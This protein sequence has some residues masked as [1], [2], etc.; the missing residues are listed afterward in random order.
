MSWLLAPVGYAA[1]VGVLTWLLRRW[2]PMW[3]KGRVVAAANAPGPLL[4]VLAVVW[5]VVRL[6][7]APPGETDATGMV[8]MVYMVGGA[9]AAG[10][11]I[12]TGSVAGLLAWRFLPSRRGG[13]TG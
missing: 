1:L 10:A 12:V 2:R 13:S 6:G 11:M 4:T 7:P 3:N 5:A 9:F 8:L